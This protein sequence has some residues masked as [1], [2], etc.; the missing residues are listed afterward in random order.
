MNPPPLSRQKGGLYW[1]HGLNSFHFFYLFC[2]FN[3]KNQNFLFLSIP[4]APYIFISKTYEISFLFITFSASRNLSMMK[5]LEGH[6]G[7]ATSL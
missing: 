1:V 7:E 4:H 5:A 2:H 3:P 6:L